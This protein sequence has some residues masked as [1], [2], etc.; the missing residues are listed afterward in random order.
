MSHFEDTHHR[1]NQTLAQAG[2]PVVLPDQ[3]DAIDQMSFDMVTV[4]GFEL[5]QFDSNFLG[6]PRR[7]KSSSTLC[8][9]THR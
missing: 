8:G 1:I 7:P 6:K 4:G 9:L 2:V 3:W 5:S